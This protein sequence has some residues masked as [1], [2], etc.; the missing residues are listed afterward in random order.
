MYD[1]L[2][3]LGYSIVIEEDVV[4]FGKCSWLWMNELEEEFLDKEVS[5][6]YVFFF[7]IIDDIKWFFFFLLK[8]YFER[9]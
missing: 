9:K 2:I 7:M 4:R 1:F 8:F 6:S 3:D 5:L